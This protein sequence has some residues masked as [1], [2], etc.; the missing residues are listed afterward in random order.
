MLHIDLDFLLNGIDKEFDENIQ[1]NTKQPDKG[2]KKS[3]VNY[4]AFIN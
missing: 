1:E 3:F 4:F 2:K